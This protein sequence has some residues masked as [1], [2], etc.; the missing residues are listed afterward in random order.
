MNA[1]PSYPHTILVGPFAQDVATISTS[2]DGLPAEKVLSVACA[3]GGA[4][5]AGTPSGLARWDAATGRWKAIAAGPLA[6]APIH[7]LRS[8]RDGGLWAGTLQDVYHFATNAPEFPDRHL[9]VTETVDLAEDASEAGRYYLLTR[10]TFLD[11]KN[12]A[13]VALPGH[14]VGQALTLNAEGSPIIATDRGLFRYADAKLRPLAPESAGANVS[15]RLLDSNVQDVAADAHGGLWV[16]TPRG[17]DYYTGDAWLE[18]SGK[19]GLPVLNIRRLAL[20]ADG[21]LWA[22][23]DRGV[24]RLAGGKWRYYAGRR[25]LPDDT[26][27]ALAA[28][29]DGSAWI[30]TDAGLS[31]IAFRTLTFAQKADHY[32]QITAA[33]HNRDGFVTD[34]RLTRPGDYTS[35]LYEASDNDGLWTSLYVCAESFRY[36]VTRDP[37]ARQRAQKS[38][39]ALLELVRVTGI[40]G[41]PARAIL[42]KG[43]RAIQSDPGPNWYPSPV[44]PDILYKDDTSSDEIDGH[45]LA[46][47]V[48]SALVADAAEKQAIAQTCRAVTNHILDHHYTLVGPTGKP[49]RWG[50]W[51]PESL[52]ADPEWAE[53]R[54]LNSLEI[55]SHLKVAIHLCGDRR[56]QDAYRDLIAK[57]HYAL[58]TVLQKRLPPEGE[59]N[60]SDDELAACAYYPLLQLE[61]DP[62]LRAL[63]LLSLERTWNILRP[64]RSPFHNVIYGA[65]TGWPCD[66][67]AAAQWLRDAP[68]DLR[69]WAMINSHR[70]DVRF[71]DAAGRFGEKQLTR[72]LPP[73][74]VRAAKWNHNPYVPDYGGDGGT[75]EDG[76]FWLLPYWMGRYHGIFG[77]AP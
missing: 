17:I 69:G 54:G 27:N 44:E 55:L 49:T 3:A 2:L 11:S 23:T 62:Q 63:Y 71:D 35:F 59:N 28:V 37:A 45:Y 60:H 29:P 24:A 36:A 8:A 7:W 15:G 68:L 14:A 18:I 43:E 31:Q 73:N 26:V 41:F 38:L 74:E 16:A 13:E 47:Y 77:E 52:N 56:F 39:K 6:S 32:E 67:E 66:A 9:S 10:H 33:R 40:P 51:S 58:N 46:W 64:E 19:D 34:C 21:A 30:A 42:R 61:T 50:V 22:G 75:E 53:E 65:C 25:W 12:H 1:L 48:Y 57:H 4:V 72:A 20:S 76:A 70:A 5:Y